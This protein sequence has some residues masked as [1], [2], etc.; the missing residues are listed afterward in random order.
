MRPRKRNLHT[1]FTKGAT[2][3]P[4]G[5]FVGKSDNW[6]SVFRQ[7]RRKIAFIYKL[8][9]GEP[10]FTPRKIC[11]LILH[12]CYTK[13]ARNVFQD[14]SVLADHLRY[15]YST[16]I[17]T[18]P[19]NV[20]LLQPRKFPVNHQFQ[21]NLAF[22]VEQKAFKISPQF[23][24]NPEKMKKRRSSSGNAISPKKHGPT[25]PNSEEKME[26]FQLPIGWSETLSI[27]RRS[28]RFW[29]LGDTSPLLWTGI[30]IK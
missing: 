1:D 16:W 14:Y 29:I 25:S 2:F 15:F 13:S 22:A 6:G 4:P 3:F 26:I 12:L 20:G 27:V 23:F 9:K 10:F 17:M 7:R 28:K 18:Y 8:I 21:W 24:E 5:Q 30:P 11:D 19:R